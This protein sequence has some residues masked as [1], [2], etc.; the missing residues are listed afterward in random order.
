MDEPVRS[1]KLQEKLSL[2]DLAPGDRGR[3]SAV[4]NLGS[5]RRRLLD[6]G[7]LPGAEVEAVMASPAGDLTAYLIRGATIALRREQARQINLE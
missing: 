6:L 3:I 7:F 2:A 5:D 1:E 4:D